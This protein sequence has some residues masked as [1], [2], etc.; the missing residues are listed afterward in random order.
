ME[1]L[2]TVPVGTRVMI[3]AA[4][5]VIIIAGVQASAALLTPFL[6]AIMF[7][8][9]CAPVLLWLERRGFPR[10]VALLLTILGIVI[11]GLMLLSVLGRAVRQMADRVPFYQQRLATQAHDL[12]V[13]L[14]A[15]GVEPNLFIPQGV[16]DGR[17]LMTAAAG[18]VSAFGLI[19]SNSLLILFIM[20]FILL[21]TSSFPNKFR[22]AFGK[23]DDSMTRFEKFNRSIHE[24][25]VIKTWISL[26]TGIT[27]FIWLL[28]FEI[29]YPILWAL[30]AFLF[31]FIPNIGSIIA[32]VPAVL[33]GLIQYG[34]DIALYVA[35]GYLF[36][37]FL[38]GYVLE[39]RF[40]GKGM[41]LSTLVVFI[42]LVFWGWVLG[43]VGL[44]LSVPLTVMVKMLLESHE[45]TRWIAIFLQSETPFL[46]R[47][48]DS[49]STDTRS[50]MG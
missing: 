38:V 8:I 35:G 25:V 3:G 15:N 48:D 10:F 13:F 24:Y 22:A 31:N 30:I 6:L 47:A 28:I 5:F 4:C 20:I 27:V 46:K 41:D 39:P 32:A 37:N 11:I 43:P 21:E 26:A 12:A 16:A 42:T 45:D 2:Q 40:M 7:S 19:I 44:L 23:A 33:L 14:Q 29:D 18:I 1:S 17:W 34:I 9:M 49:H 36:V 50:H